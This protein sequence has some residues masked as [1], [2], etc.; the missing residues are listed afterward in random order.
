MGVANQLGLDG[1]QGGRVESR[2][3]PCYVVD[4]EDGTRVLM[5]AAERL[6]AVAVGFD[7]RADVEQAVSVM[8]VQGQII[9]KNAV[10]N[11]AQHAGVE[12]HVHILAKPG[13][14]R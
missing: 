12:L 2:Y 11:I 13:R 9:M 14:V 10:Q 8:L 6:E 1:P 3:Q 4:N 5:G 7:D